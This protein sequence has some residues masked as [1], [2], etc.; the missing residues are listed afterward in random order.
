MRGKATRWLSIMLVVSLCAAVPSCDRESAS[1]RAAS[2]AAQ[3]GAGEPTADAAR[4]EPPE[5]T[6][7]WFSHNIRVWDDVLGPFKGKPELRYLQVGVFEGRSLLWVLE[8]V[9]TH[10]TSELTGI[11]IEI[12]PTL[13]ANLEN[14]GQADRV[15]ILHG[16]S[17]VELR[18]LP[19]ESFDIIYIDGSHTPDD[20]L[21]DAVLSWEL[22]KTGGLVIFDDYKWDGSYYTGGGPLPVELLPRSAIESFIG[23]YRHE[24]SEVHRAYQVILRKEENPCG[25]IKAHCSLFHQYIYDWQEHRLLLPGRTTEAIEISERERELIE[26]ILLS[27]SVDAGTRSDRDY[28][29]MRGRLGLDAG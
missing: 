24:L 2:G 6:T 8:N 23:A 21:A 29:R 26:T 18:K 4:A 10:P 19:T 16:P 12:S 14:S 13:L 20:V 3:A 9:L 28:L 5:F 27:G 1:E 11:D 22:L 7:D 15:T 17:Q 25:E